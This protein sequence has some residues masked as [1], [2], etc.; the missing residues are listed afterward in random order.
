VLA[1]AAARAL[2]RP[3]QAGDIDPVSVRVARDNVRLNHAGPFVRVVQANGLAGRRMQE[4]APYD[5]VFANILLGPVRL[6]ATPIRRVTAPGAHVI[7]S[8]LLASQGTAAL[9]AYRARGFVLE[10]R[11]VLDGWMTLVLARQ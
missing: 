9:A 4:G 2:R 1:I 3:V 5:L 6:L 8:G 10:R 11:I 7:I